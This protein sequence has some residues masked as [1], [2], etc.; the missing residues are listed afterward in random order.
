MASYRFNAT[1]HLAAANAALVPI[2]VYEARIVD[3][4]RRLARSGDGHFLQFALQIDRGDHAGR[5]LFVR[6]HVGSSQLTVRQLA[7]QELA[8]LCAAVGLGSFSTTQQ[9]HG[10]RLLIDVGVKQRGPGD[11]TN[12][13][14]SYRQLAARADHTD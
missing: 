9:L 4:M 1:V 7:E 12:T 8:A 2:G 5:V 3:S 10:R 14:R 13:V 11:F 6:L